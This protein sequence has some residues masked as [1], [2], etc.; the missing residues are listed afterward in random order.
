M[1]GHV[2]LGLG[3]DCELLNTGKRREKLWVIYSEEVLEMFLEEGNVY[4]HTCCWEY[5]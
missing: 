1:S 3:V 5:E 4:K 2:S